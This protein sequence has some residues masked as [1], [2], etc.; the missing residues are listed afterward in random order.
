M[1]QQKSRLA[2]LLKKYENDVLSEWVQDQ[3]KTGRKVAVSEQELRQ[4]CSEF[5]IEFVKS[6][7][8]SQ[9]PANGDSKSP[10]RSRFGPASATLPATSFMSSM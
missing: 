2:D 9:S 4:E 10:S 6:A 1:P 7:V 8:N 3:L 5:L